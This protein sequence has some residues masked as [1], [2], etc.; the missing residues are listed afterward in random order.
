MRIIYW[1]WWDQINAALFISAVAG[2]LIVLSLELLGVSP[3]R[4]GALVLFENFGKTDRSD[5]GVKLLGITLSAG[6]ACGLWILS[7]CS[8]RWALISR[9]RTMVNAFLDQMEQHLGGGPDGLTPP[10]RVMFE[11]ILDH[12]PWAIS[13][14]GDKLLLVHGKSQRYVDDSLRYCRYCR[15]LLRSEAEVERGGDEDGA[16]VRSELAVNLGCLYVAACLSVLYLNRT[17]RH[18]RRTLARAIEQGSKATSL[19]VQRDLLPDVRRFLPP[20]V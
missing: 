14:L 9:L 12:H 13:A 5:L 1:T 18:D 10:R 2:F 19:D 16:A 17:P 8:E 7:K 3:W 20:Q 11:E 4:T 15:G 6:A